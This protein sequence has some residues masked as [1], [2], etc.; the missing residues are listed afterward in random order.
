MI[1][2]VEPVPQAFVELFEG[3][4]N[5]GIE[6]GQKLL[7]HGTE[8]AFNLAASFGLIGRG[9]HD[10]DAD[11]SGDAGQLRGSVDLGV[12]HVEAGGE[13]TGGGGPGQ[14]NEEKSPPPGG[15]KKGVRGGGGGAGERGVEKKP[16]LCPP[17]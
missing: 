1:I 8:E 12:V 15:G 7:A 5:F 17:R 9:V 13:G 10:E 6:R 2:G 14:A 4:Q 3:E 16:V 11:G